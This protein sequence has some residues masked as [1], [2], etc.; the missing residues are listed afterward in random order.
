[1]KYSG[2][3]V[4]AKYFQ[5]E[6]GLLYNAQLIKLLCAP[7]PCRSVRCFFSPSLSNALPVRPITL[8]HVF[9]L[10]RSNE[11]VCVCVCFNSSFSNKGQHSSQ[12]VT[13]SLGR[14]GC[15]QQRNGIN[16]AAQMVS[17]C[18]RNFRRLAAKVSHRS[19][20]S[21]SVRYIQT[22]EQSWDAD[23]AGACHVYGSLRVPFT[24]ATDK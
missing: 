20:G 7:L 3:A 12:Q 5:K 13:S 22:T 18:L 10:T 4:R 9:V 11:R 17:T 21:E 2:V 6:S 24:N 14:R 8:K 19:S 1:M 16:A 23:G 15:G